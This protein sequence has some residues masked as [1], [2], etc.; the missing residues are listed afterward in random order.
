[1][2]KQGEMDMDELIELV[3]EQIRLDLEV[4]HITSLEELLRQ[5]PEETLVGFLTE[6][7]D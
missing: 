7:T 5:L 2:M 1:M 4:G 6:A 3:V